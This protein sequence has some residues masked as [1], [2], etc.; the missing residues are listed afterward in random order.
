MF[1]KEV[2]YFKIFIVSPYLFDNIFFSVGHISFLV[3][4][5]SDRIHKSGLPL[6]GSGSERNIYVSSTLIMTMMNL[7][8]GQEEGEH[9]VQGAG[10]GLLQPAP[11]QGESRHSQGQTQ[12]QVGL[13]HTQRFDSI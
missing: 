5:V 9:G 11:G 8:P 1:N 7:I 6:R 4:S 2:Q 10:G 3:G 13:P 12:G